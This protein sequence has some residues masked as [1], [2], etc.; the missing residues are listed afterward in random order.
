[1]NEQRTRRRSRNK[2]TPVVQT[3]REAS[4]AATVYADRVA[5]FCTDEL[6]LSQHPATITTAPAGCAT[7]RFCSLTG[8]CGP[9]GCCQYEQERGWADH[10]SSP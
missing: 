6:G 5:P 7:P 1:M 10:N 4:K 9:D 8:P 3:E 2:K